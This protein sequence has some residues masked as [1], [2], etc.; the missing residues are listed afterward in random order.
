[1]HAFPYLGEY[2]PEIAEFI[3]TCEFEFEGYLGLLRRT[4]PTPPGEDDWDYIETDDS[5][6]GA[7]MERFIE[8][9]PLLDEFIR[10]KTL[11]AQHIRI[12]L[13]DPSAAALRSD[14]IN[15]ATQEHVPD[16]LHVIEHDDS[17]VYRQHAIYKLEKLGIGLDR[18]KDILLK[19]TDVTTTPEYTY[20]L[21]L[22]LM[23]ERFEEPRWVRFREPIG[24]TDSGIYLSPPGNDF[25]EALHDD[26]AWIPE[27]LWKT[28]GGLSTYHKRKA[29]AVYRLHQYRHAVANTLALK[30]LPGLESI[31]VETAEYALEAARVTPSGDNFFGWNLRASYLGLFM[32]TINSLL[33]TNAKLCGEFLIAH[34][35]DPDSGINY[36]VHKN[37]KRQVALNATVAAWVA[38]HSTAE[39]QDW[40]T[41]KLSHKHMYEKKGILRFRKGKWDFC[42][43]AL[44]RMPGEYPALRKYIVGCPATP[45]DFNVLGPLQYTL[46][47]LIELSPE[48]AERFAKEHDNYVRSLA[49]LPRRMHYAAL[50]SEYERLHGQQI[51]WYALTQEMIE[52]T[53]RESPL[54]SKI[55]GIV[56]VK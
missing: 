45:V 13:L 54:L 56:L 41:Y 12:L 43:P 22:Q 34:D 44:L 42:G 55:Q 25:L 47:G 50:E 9:E 15:D 23:H 33:L 10:R 29:R 1:M 36:I 6:G 11:D 38:G 17:L 48:Q 46:S 24:K 27:G 37:L 7:F 40:I 19:R 28:A 39:V 21:A 8:L 16:L 18:V 20:R 26:A 5:F 35:N 2:D 51:S 49:F 53:R 30:E 31:L 52:E 32:Y 14:L 4:G 3:R